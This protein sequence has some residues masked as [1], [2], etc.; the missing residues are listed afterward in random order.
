LEKGHGITPGQNW[1]IR[2]AAA[3]RKAADPRMR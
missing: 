2:I 3:A 1:K